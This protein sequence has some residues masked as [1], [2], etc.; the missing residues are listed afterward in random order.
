MTIINGY[1]KDIRNKKFNYSQ[2]DKNVKKYF[3]V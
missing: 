2:I 1:G 3:I